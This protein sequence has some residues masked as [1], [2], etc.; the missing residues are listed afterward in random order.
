MRFIHISPRDKTVEFIEADS[1]E[2]A[3]PLC[4]LKSGEID[5]GELGLNRSIAVYEYGLIEET[6]LG[7]F[8]LGWSLY[9]GNALVFAYDT[10]GETVS[11]TD[12][13]LDIARE[14]TTFYAT[15]EE[16][17]ASIAAGKIRRPE[18]SVGGVVTWSWNKGDST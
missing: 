1:F 7:Y 4:G 8:S 17:E 14:Y 3:L 16:V 13:D 12:Q 10:E 15:K 5:F 11:V 2:E 18:S 9:A 6:G